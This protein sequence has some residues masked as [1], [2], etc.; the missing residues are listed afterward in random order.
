MK[1]AKFL[2][3]VC[4]VV[5]A[6]GCN[7]NRRIFVEHDYSY[8]TNFKAYSTYA[9][10]E[11]E[12]DTGNVCTEVY[13]AIHRQMQA[14]GYRLSTSKPTLLVNYGIFYD[15]LRYQ[16]Y[17][18]PVIKN[19]VDTEDDSFKYEPIRYSLDKGTIII[20][21]IDADT[22]QVVWRGYAAGIF[23]NPNAANSYYR[24]VVRSIFDQYPLF[25]SGYDPRGGGPQESGR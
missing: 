12:R 14:R 11:C 4:V 21:L 2:P 20:S 9:F 16:G 18:Q 10:L 6:A 25:A 15:N 19:W 23:K 17:M 13:N 1:L 7:T 24:N 22:D 5:W 3:F 8:E